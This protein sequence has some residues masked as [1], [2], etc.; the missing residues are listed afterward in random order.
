MH[1]AAEGHADVVKVLLKYNADPAMRD[2]DGDSARDFAMRNR[3][4]DV[5]QL[6][7]N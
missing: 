2:A 4:A 3:H 1:A 6:L 5:V 7:A